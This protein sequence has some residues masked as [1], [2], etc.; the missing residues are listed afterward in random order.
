[1]TIQQLAALQNWLTL[2]KALNDFTESELKEMLDYEFDTQKR[3][4]FM[5]RIH[6]RFCK[7]R[8]KREW[9]LLGG[10]NPPKPQ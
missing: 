4:T 7:L 9:E 2:N 8:T 10:S 6:E 5:K 3:K 1:M